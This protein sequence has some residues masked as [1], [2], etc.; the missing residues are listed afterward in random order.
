MTLKPLTTIKG[1]GPKRAAVFEKAGVNSI[2]DLL[3]LM[4]NDYCDFSQ[5]RLT[6]DLNHGD[7]AVIKVRAVNNAHLYRIKKNL[8]IL[9][10]SAEDSS[11]RIE[12][13]W[14]NQPFR[15]GGLKAGQQYYACGKIDKSRNIRMLNP[16]ICDKPPGILPVY[17]QVK[18]VS[19]SQ[20][21]NIVRAALDAGHNLIDDIFPDRFKKK[22][23]LMDIA[24]AIRQIHTPQ[25]IESVL[26]AR[27]RIEFEEIFLFL[28]M[29]YSFRE[30]GRDRKGIA[31]RTEGLAEEFVKLLPFELT[32][33]QKKVIREVT[34][35]MKKDSPMNRMIQGD[36]GSGKTVI[37]M[38]AIFAAVRNGYQGAL[39][40]PTEV[41]AEQH[42]QTFIDIF[43]ED[44]CLLT[45]RVKKLE[46][47]KLYSRIRSADVKVVIGTQALIQSGVEFSNLGVVVTDEQHRFGVRQRAF[48][49]AKGA[50]PDVLVM[51]ATPI[52]RSLALI[53]YGDLDISVLDELPP[54]RKKILT[55]N[56]ASDKRMEMY[57]YI[58]KKV[59]EGCQ[60]YIVC[61]LIEQSDSLDARS[62]LEVYNEL[63]EIIPNVKIGLLHGQLP[64]NQKEDTLEKFRNGEID[65]LVCTTVIEVGIDVPGASIMVIENADRFGLSQL[66]QLRGRVG[67]G[68]Q[69][70][71]C[72]LLSGSS[73][74]NA[75]ERLDLMARTQDGFELSKIDLEF[76]G[77]GEFI[78]LRQHGKDIAASKYVANT[79]LLFEAQEAAE[80][81]LNFEK[82][83]KIANK[84]I[85]AAQN[86]YLSKFTHIASN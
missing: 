17:A 74:P 25:S 20:M 37:A 33:A 18:G 82:N 81:L 72:F 6:S 40:V 69:R 47:D 24:E 80:E 21:R 54:G 45:G 58:E 76:R 31:F 14:Y 56:V 57:A 59:K 41:L 30:S 5:V 22:Y 86:K 43:G 1:V 32:S 13:V 11:G 36:V 39:M 53:L 67:R 70:S 2:E 29:L 38:Y 44:V 4:P 60:G 7:V 46:R 12:L 64:S 68:N 77:P 52:P 27:R 8:N 15:A 85:A 48:L 73:S 23:N 3:R 79:G 71:Y 35:D 51:S 84:I 49:S 75:K 28:A 19:Q 10:I 83:K 9:S 50:A 78:G 55:K 42:F 65:L 63:R 26:P 62:A 61:P 66:H 16:I 34:D